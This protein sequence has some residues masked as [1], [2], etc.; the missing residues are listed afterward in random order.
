MTA[1]PRFV[2][3]LRSFVPHGP[4]AVLVL[5]SGALNVAAGVRG[6]L[7][8]V[9]VVGSQT[10]GALNGSLNV[11]GR[12]TQTT[13]GVALLL[14]AIGLA[15]RLRPAWGF[16]LSLSL[17]TVAVNIA[18]QQFGASLVL[19]GLIL[20]ALLVWRSAFT[21]R[22]AISNYVISIFSIGGVLAYG[23][24][25]SYLLGAG[26]RPAITSLTTSLYF[27]VVT[28]STVGYGDIVPITGETRLFTATLIVGGIGIFATAVASL[29]GPAITGEL[30]RIFSPQSRRMSFTDH[31]IVT[32]S[33]PVAEN[34]VRELAQRKISYVRVVKIESETAR[35]DDERV[36]V[37]DPTEE[38][39][40]C[41]AGIAGARLV[42]AAREDDSE[43]AF[44]SLLAKD[45]NPRVQ[46]LAVATTSRAIRRLK[47]ARADVAFAPS[48]VG[49]RLVADLVEGSA[50][51]DQFTD[52]VSGE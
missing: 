28:V 22:T 34:T 8:G 17:V 49:G 41:R 24:V 5:L 26:Y 40:L 50:I 20:V 1:V 33:G 13:L 11:L 16:A 48:A 52:L 42:I 4:L 45:L 30:G 43:N 9:S 15:F 35:A 7:P 39:V 27:T 3:R 51:P 2:T 47:L 29:L 36:V 44:I 38:S 37:G 10:L 46:V 12:G 14:I 21:R 25:G 18:R 19:P 31:V 23:I 6:P 32:G